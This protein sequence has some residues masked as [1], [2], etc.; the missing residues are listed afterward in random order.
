VRGSEQRGGGGDAAGRGGA[1]GSRCRST[2]LS[3]TRG[4]SESGAGG[5]TREVETPL[6]SNSPHDHM[7][8]GVELVGSHGRWKGSLTFKP[9]ATRTKQCSTAKG[10]STTVSRSYVRLIQYSDSSALGLVRRWLLNGYFQSTHYHPTRTDDGHYSRIRCRAVCAT[11]CC[12]RLRVLRRAACG[13][14]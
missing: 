13:A 12:G 11:Q 2:P 14:V 8:L 4:E 10:S 6:P 3:P 9:P 7:M 1:V 5:L